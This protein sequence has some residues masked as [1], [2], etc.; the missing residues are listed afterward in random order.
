M[1]LVD[2]GVLYAQRDE[3]APRHAIAH[4]ALE[5]TFAGS[6]GRPVVSDYIVDETFTLTLAR[7]RRGDLARGVLDWIFGTGGGPGRFDLLWVTQHGFRRAV[8]IL[9]R[10]SDHA[11]SFTD[12][13]TVALM[14]DHDVDHLLSFDE[15]FDG[16]VDRLDP[17][18]LPK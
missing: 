3:D 9:D 10:F 1:I 12:A 11:L 8:E 13:T 2:S 18:D 15:G 7:T 14:E 6:Y 16:I 5:S 17:A 4:P